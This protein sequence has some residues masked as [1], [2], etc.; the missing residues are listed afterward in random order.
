MFAAALEVDIP[1]DGVVSMAFNPD[2][3]WQF[4]LLTKYDIWIG[5][6]Q[7][8]LVSALGTQVISMMKLNT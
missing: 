4:L 8:N 1:R 5:V 3:S 7:V 6:S 2:N